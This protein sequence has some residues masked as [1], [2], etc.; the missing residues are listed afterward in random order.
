MA[1]HGRNLDLDYIF[2]TV[3][4]KVTVDGCQAPFLI[5]LLWASDLGSS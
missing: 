1:W 3:V 2:V 4:K 5:S